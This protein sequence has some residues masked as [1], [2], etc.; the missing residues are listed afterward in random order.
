MAEIKDFGEKIGGARKDM[1]ASRGLIQADLIDMTDLERQ[2]HVKKD[3]VWIRPDWEKL[4]AEGV[5]QGIAYW[6]NKM[7]QAVPPKPPANTE[8]AQRN[9]VEVV[10]RIRDAVMDVKTP[11]ELD[12][13][14]QERLRPA[15]IDPNSRGYYVTIIPEADGIVNNKV[16]KAA[17]SKSWRMEDEAK[18]KLFGVPK[19]EKTYT[20]V[21]NGLSIY[22]FD[23]DRV[24][25]APDA[26][27]SDR[28]CLKVKA[29]Y[30]SSFYYLYP[31]D[32]FYNVD[33][34]QKDTYF[35]MNDNSRKP[36]R[37][38][39]ATKEE[40]ERFVESF[41]RDAQALADKR[42][43][44]NP[45]EHDSNRKKAF[46]PPL[47][48]H[49]HR[50]G[51]EYRLGRFVDGDVF[52]NEL[53]FRAGEFGN[54]LSNDERQASLNMGYEAF[55]DLARVLCIRPED[56]ALNNNLAIAFG[57][58]GRGGANAAAAHYEPDRQVINLTK[59]SGAGCLAHEWGHALDHAIGRAFGGVGLASEMKIKKDLPAAFKDLLS[60][61]KYK[62]VTI[63]AGEVSAQQKD[64]VN[65]CR[66]QLSKWIAAE[67]PKNLTDEMSKKWDEICGRITSSSSSITGVEY[68]PFGRRSKDVVT[69][70]DIE[71]LSR[72]RKLAT[73]HSIPKDTKQQIVIWASSLKSAE[74]QLKSQEP[75]V[76]QVKTDF[77][78]GAEEFDKVFAR[79]GHGY[80]K[81]DCEMFARA[82]DCYVADKIK[83]EGRL[84]QY[85][86]AHADAFVMPGND[87]EMISAVPKG[88][89]REMLNKKFDDLFV[90]LKE[91]G[92]L[93]DY[94]EELEAVK[95][96]EQAPS[97]NIFEKMQNMESTERSLYTQMSFDDLFASPS[98]EPTKAPPSNRQRSDSSFER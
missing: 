91:R 60:S 53:K 98:P 85:L 40:A 93:Q 67:R 37:I 35:V 7:R 19:D 46:V 15:F 66:T 54:W 73:N 76:R 70:P 17:Q 86:T 49:V 43:S 21:K 96:K 18:K 11:R 34:W 75:V 90:D 97:Q 1:W 44:E 71:M 92:I 26:Y 4:I 56:V 95:P 62:T 55:R 33:D 78:K 42:E 65:K 61:M 14:Y 29:S 38:N 48:R 89:E 20:A 69:N 16:L 31:K 59:M 84:S 24:S 52:L 80:W 87:G 22:K 63:E 47:L 12:Y 74:E 51:P 39:F 28:L 10:G 30:G 45:K 81:S 68:M 88:E 50:K 41:S 64:Q 77:Y 82:F 32:K 94:L 23:A 36:L 3:N 5:P 57:A 27:S 72:I 13:F 8:E 83:D 9:Y 25:I 79:G 58:R 2:N 6:Q